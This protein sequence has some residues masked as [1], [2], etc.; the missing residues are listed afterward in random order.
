MKVKLQCN[1][2]LFILNLPSGHEQI[3][4]FIL[5]PEHLSHWSGEFEQAE[6]IGEHAKH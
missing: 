6:Q 4:K 2:L 3:G 1:L 5:I